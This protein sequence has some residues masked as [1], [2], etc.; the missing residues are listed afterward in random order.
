MD[1]DVNPT[2]SV[3]CRTVRLNVG[4]DERPLP[5]PVF[6][7]A[8]VTVDGPTLHTVGPLDLRIH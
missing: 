7:H 3:D 4:V 5:S 1:I 8:R 6:P 2:V